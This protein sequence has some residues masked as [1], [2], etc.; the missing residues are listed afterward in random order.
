MRASLRAQP[1]FH[2]L[3]HSSLQLIQQDTWNTYNSEN[4]VSKFSQI[5]VVGTFR[6]GGSRK[7]IQSVRRN[8]RLVI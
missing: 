1:R 8:C 5:R 6:V 2:P 4:D 7:K 3:F